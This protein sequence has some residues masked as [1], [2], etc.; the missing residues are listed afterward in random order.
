MAAPL[1]SMGAK[2]RPDLFLPDVEPGPIWLC[3]RNF[4]CRSELRNE[5]ASRARGLNRR[6]SLYV[7]LRAERS[8]HGM[9]MVFLRWNTRAQMRC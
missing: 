1:V 6:L 5:F 8:L 9:A 3:R 2:D 7:V 4:I